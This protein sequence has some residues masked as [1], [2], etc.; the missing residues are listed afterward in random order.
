MIV[1]K[2][3]KSNHAGKLII[4]GAFIFTFFVTGFA[5]APNYGVAL[6]MIYFAGIMHSVFLVISMTAIQM[7]LPSNYRGRVMGIYTISFAL[8]PLGGLM[9]GNIAEVLD[10]RW[11]L[12]ISAGILAVIMAATFATQRELRTLRGDQLTTLEEPNA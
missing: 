8:M 1:P 4:G 11:A 7:R 5:F 9:G 2:L 12:T 10:E 3:Q 6:A